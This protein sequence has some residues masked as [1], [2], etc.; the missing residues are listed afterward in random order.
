[1]KVSVGQSSQKGR[2]AAANQD[3]HG[4]YV[5]DEP[6]LS[7]K[8]ICIALADGISS[9][10]VSQIASE[11]AVKVFLEDYYCTSEAWSVRTSGD[12]VLAAINSWLYSQTRHSQFRYEQDKGYVCTFSG[13]VLKSRTGHLFHAG[14]AR[15]YRLEGAHLEQLTDDHRLRISDETSYLSRALG[16]NERV[17]VD[18]REIPVEPGDLFV[19]AT[20]G[21]YE[22]TSE[23]AM[24]DSIRDHGEDLDAAALAIVAAAYANGSADDLTVQLVRVVDLPHPSPTE[25]MEVLLELPLPPELRPGMTFD[26]YRIVRQL[27]ASHRSHVYL[28]V[29]EEDGAE[30]AI[31]VPSVD[32]REDASFLERFMAEEWV[33]RR[34][35]NPHVLKPRAQTRARRFAYLVTDY[36]E[37]QT[38]AQWMLDHPKPDLETVRRLLEQVVAGLQ[39]FHRQEMLHQD[40]R[41]ENIMID[42]DGTVKI[43][44]FGSAR[45]AG[46]DEL[47]GPGEPPLLLGTVQY[48]APEYF[49]GEPGGQASDVFSLGVIAY[50]MLSGR[51]PYGAAVPH[52]RT[53]AAQRRLRY[54]SVLDPARD[55]PAWVDATLKKAVHPDPERRY[56]ELSEFAYD[57]RRPNRDL[58]EGAR[59][60]LLERDPA[61]FWKWVSFLLAIMVLIL[62]L[63]R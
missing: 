22:H 59:P 42:R 24:V 2:K 14:D 9:S 60:P 6:L 53:R 63:R 21:V 44:D 48:A 62:F 57:L 52:A 5:P 40:L 49:L 18:Y 1:M 29:D 10:A 38:L 34:I 43:I 61:A 27:H 50:Q 47:Q 17:D 8:G 37:G 26:G 7:S 46:I 36:I 20:D 33:S 19:F 4:V 32:R 55:I 58:V 30:V 45:V 56:A 51:L 25:L 28:A 54:R 13:M 39:A 15:I 35:N 12:R 16:I 31:K 11:S 41:P 3:F 23:R